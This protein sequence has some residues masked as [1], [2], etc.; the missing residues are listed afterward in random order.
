[1]SRSSSRS[2]FACNLVVHFDGK[3]VKLADGTVEERLAILLYRVHPDS[4]PHFIA[5]PRTPNGTGASMRDA[6]VATLA[7]IGVEDY[8]ILGMSSDTTASNTGAVSG[9][10]SLFEQTLE[11]SLLW[12]MCRHHVAEVHITWADHAVRNAVAPGGKDPMLTR[13][14]NYFPMLDLEDLKLYEPL[15][16]DQHLAAGTPGC[17]TWFSYQARYILQWAVQVNRALTWLRE[18]N[19]QQL[20]L[21]IVFFRGRDAQGRIMRS[22]RMGNQFLHK[23]SMQ[24]PGAV[25]HARFMSRANQYMQLYM[26]M[27]QIPNNVITRHERNQIHRVACWCFYIYAKYFLQAMLPA[28]APRLDLEFF[29]EN[30]HFQVLFEPDNKF[31]AD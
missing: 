2:E 20:E 31:I 28:Q 22:T 6:L 5:A 26:T 15:E 23:W 13:F 16:A 24:K 19:R 14:A 7:G 1:M 3:K 9:A 21:L 4:K 18:D 25:H 12:F 17:E 11:T 29:K 27:H 10:A 30:H 8:R